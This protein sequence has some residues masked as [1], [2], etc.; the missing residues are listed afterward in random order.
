M[1][2]DLATTISLIIYCLFGIAYFIVFAMT[3]LDIA[4][5]SVSFL[6]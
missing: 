4:L 2:K 6:F 5:D 1:M 3:F